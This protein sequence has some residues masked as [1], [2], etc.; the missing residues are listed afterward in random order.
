MAANPVEKRLKYGIVQGSSMIFP[1]SSARILKAM[2]TAG[3]IFLPGERGLD[4]SAVERSA[5]GVA[6]IFFH[7]IHNIKF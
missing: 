6:R 7:H 4:L 3:G 1:G 2:R 5:W